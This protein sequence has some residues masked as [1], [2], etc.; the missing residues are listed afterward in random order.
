MGGE[1]GLRKS[2]VWPAPW[3][4]TARVE[5]V[6]PTAATSGMTIGAMTALAPA[7]VPSRV[8][9][10]IELT[11]VARMA[12]FWVLT[13]I[14]RIRMLTM[15]AATPVLRSTMPRPEPSMMIKPT[16][17]KKEPIDS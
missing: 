2:P 17:A 9:R 5:G 6:M 12:R 11:I 14:L 15:A 1:K 3:K 16:R 8:T 7:R 4:I 13:P 10:Q